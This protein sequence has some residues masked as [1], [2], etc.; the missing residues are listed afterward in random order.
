MSKEDE[1]KI[2]KRKIKKYKRAWKEVNIYLADH[3]L[4]PSSIG[5][6]KVLYYSITEK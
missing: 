3:Y 1:I 6:I 5:E 4:S 2:L